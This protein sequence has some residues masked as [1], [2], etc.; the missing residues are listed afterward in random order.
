MTLVFPL[1]CLGR[2]YE[3]QENQNPAKIG[4]FHEKSAKFFKALYLPS[5]QALF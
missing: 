5:N 2:L 4:L 3:K 1:L